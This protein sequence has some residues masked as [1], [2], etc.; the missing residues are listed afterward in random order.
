MRKWISISLALMLLWPQL[1]AYGEAAPQSPDQPETYEV[2]EGDLTSQSCLVMDLS[3][4]E[5]L[6]DKNA[7]QKAYM[8][9]LTKLMTALI[10]SEN[11]S[12]RK[13]IKSKKDY[14]P[15]LDKYNGPMSLVDA[16]G[17]YKPILKGETFKAKELFDVMMIYSAN[18]AALLFAD[19]ISG[20]EKA[21]VKKM[22]S[23]AKALGMTHTRFTNV[24]GM[25]SAGDEVNQYTT[26]KDVA[27]LAKKAF[28]NPQ[29]MA[30][31]SKS[32]AP[33]NTNFRKGVYHSSN[34]L[35]TLRTG[36]MGLKT[37]YTKLAGN[38]FASV[39]KLDGRPY[40]AVTLNAEFRS[41]MFEDHMSLYNWLE[42]KLGLREPEPKLETP[43]TVTDVTSPDGV[44]IEII[45]D[46]SL[47]SEGNN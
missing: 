11:L 18:D 12:L 44:I 7:D 37:G 2:F 24:H 26:A 20:S 32:E 8:A 43:P 17:K 16:K 34:K 40:M 15:L 35:M 45:P 38:C 33:L 22:N 29:I 30:A 5:I 23:R 3:S 21:F 41:K 10:V 4:G 31:V 6:Y 25:S 39:V 1:S 19:T 42:V 14:K 9:S 28:T 27:I 36:V 13:T 46:Y 47:Q